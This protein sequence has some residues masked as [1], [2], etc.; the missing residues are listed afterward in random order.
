VSQNIGICTEVFSMRE[1]VD[2]AVAGEA[3]V[4][5]EEITEAP[6][7]VRKESTEMIHTNRYIKVK[8]VYT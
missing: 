7:Y 2:R 4:G 5:E 3:P 6:H 1:L 8:C